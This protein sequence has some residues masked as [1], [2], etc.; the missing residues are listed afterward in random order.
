MTS[1]VE[2]V[3][4]YQTGALMQLTSPEKP[5]KI[6]SLLHLDSVE[7]VVAVAAAAEPTV[8]VV[9]QQLALASM[10]TGP[11]ASFSFAL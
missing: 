9:V 1:V 7:I 2:V 10:L 4:A 6:Q 5:K 3:A 8:I 11:L